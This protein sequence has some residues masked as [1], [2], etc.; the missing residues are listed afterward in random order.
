MQLRLRDTEVRIGYVLMGDFTGN[1]LRHLISRLVE[2]DRIRLDRFLR[3]ED[4]LAFALGRQ[5]VQT[6]L[7]ECAPEPSGGWPLEVGD[8][9]KPRLLRSDNVP[10]LRFN[11]THSAGLVAVAVTLGREVGIDAESVRDDIDHFEIARTYLPTAEVTLLRVL[12]GKHQRDAFFALWT[13]REAYL[14]ATGQGITTPL[15]HIHFALDPP[16]AF[17]DSSDVA[18]REWFL[19]QSK[20]TPSHIVA[21]AAHS[22]PS[23]T[24]IC[25]Q[26]L[27]HWKDFCI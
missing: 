18:L 8:S 10:D 12:D 15:P 11:I 19:W 9:G 3:F 23:E 14:K 25:Q 26:K 22:H 2:T 1:A 16:A 7:S 13:L 4:K 21:V 5:L 17:L 27:F 24:L 20:I 6:M